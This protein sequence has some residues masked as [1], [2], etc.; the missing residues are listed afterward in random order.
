MKNAIS[1]DLS[2]F[3]RIKSF[4]WTVHVNH[5]SSSYNQTKLCQSPH[6]TP[7][8]NRIIPGDDDGAQLLPPGGQFSNVLLRLIAPVVPG[9]ENNARDFSPSLHQHPL[10]LRDLCFRAVHAVLAWP[11][12]ELD[13]QAAHANRNPCSAL[14]LGPHW[15]AEA[16]CWL[17]ST[18]P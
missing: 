15:S 6:P 7:S 9:V 5:M 18:T 17:P 11:A 14:L 16:V 12:Q 10:R 4:H 1:I 13:V 3:Y 2:L 8:R